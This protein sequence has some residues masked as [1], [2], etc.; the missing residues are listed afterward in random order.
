MECRLYEKSPRYF[1]SSLVVVE[2][3][4]LPAILEVIHELDEFDLFSVFNLNIN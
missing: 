3:E 2:C 4:E 1:G